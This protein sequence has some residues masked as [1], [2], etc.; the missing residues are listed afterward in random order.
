MLH[1][2]QCILPI[3]LDGDNDYDVLIGYVIQNNITAGFN[4]GTSTVANMQSQDTAFPVYN[5][6]VASFTLNV[7][8]YLDLDNDGIKDLQV[9][10]FQRNVSDNFNSVWYYK[11]LGT[12]IYPNFSFQKPDYLQVSPF[13]RNVSDNFNS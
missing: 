1:A 13:Q 12:N 4:A 2:G 7:P 5:V 9:S 6:P 8:F 11:N 3:D 10:P